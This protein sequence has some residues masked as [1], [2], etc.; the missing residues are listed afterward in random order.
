M[1]QKRG[2]RLVRFYQGITNPVSLDDA[3][4]SNWICTL[5]NIEQSY[6]NIRETEFRSEKQNLDLRNR[7]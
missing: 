6:T 2:N 4:Y 3:K 1:S 5:W 7:I